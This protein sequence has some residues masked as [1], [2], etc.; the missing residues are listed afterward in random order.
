MLT[1]TGSR[2][3]GRKGIKDC[4]F[5]KLLKSSAVKAGREM[6]AAPERG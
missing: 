4:E 5:W 1:E 2:E 3:N 6:E